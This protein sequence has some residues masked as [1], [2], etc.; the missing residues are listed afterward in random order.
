MYVSIILLPVCNKCPNLYKRYSYQMPKC[1]VT[2]EL[3]IKVASADFT[4][5]RAQN[6]YLLC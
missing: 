1:I 5:H 6:T 3:R 4:A 2:S